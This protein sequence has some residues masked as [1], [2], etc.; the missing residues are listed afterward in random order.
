MADNT[1]DIAPKKARKKPASRAKK[2]EVVVPTKTLGEIAADAKAEELD[3][4][5]TEDLT[6]EALAQKEEIPAALTEVPEILQIGNQPVVLELSKQA[7]NWKN[8]L[9]EKKLTPEQF[10]AKYPTNKMKH[11]IQEIVD[12]NNKTGKFSI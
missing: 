5:T 3:F 10:L 11:F 4:T 2:E 7:T 9:A 1:E 8:F 12:F 6:K